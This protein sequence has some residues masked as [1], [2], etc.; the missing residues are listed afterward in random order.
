MQQVIP[1]KLQKIFRQIENC[2]R[3][4]KEKNPLRHILGG[5][6]FR[7]PKYFFLFI[8]PTHK[9][10]S[11]HA[12]YK[13]ERRYPFIGVRHFYKGLA[14]TGFVDKKLVADIYKRGW[15]LEDEKRIENSLRANGVYISNFVK[16]AQANPINPPRKVMREHL[17]LLARELKLVNPKYVVTFGVLPLS[18]LTGVTSCLRDIL[19][20]IHNGMYRPLHSIPLDG[21]KYQLLP[22]YYPLGHGNPPKAHKILTYIR[23]YF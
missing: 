17:P 2:E 3:C 15:Q 19:A 8:N 9:N 13:G 4:R 11:S 21:R 1:L 10:H 14:E 7:N 16:C 23:T 22:C 6:K 18:T 12:H 20:T 5:G